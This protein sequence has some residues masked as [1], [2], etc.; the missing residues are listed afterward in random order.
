M[1]RSLDLTDLGRIRIG[2]AADL[3]VWNAEGS[4]GSSECMVNQVDAILVG[5]WPVSIR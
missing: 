1:A 3:V 4:I 2:A 5:G